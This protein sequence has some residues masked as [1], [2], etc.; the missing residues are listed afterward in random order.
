MDYNS[1]KVLWELSKSL[2]VIFF[3]ISFRQHTKTNEFEKHIQHEK[4][5][6]IW[7]NLLS[8]Y[9]YKSANQIFLNIDV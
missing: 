4:W 7:E 8:K 9:A 1:S 3:I 5:V 6:P 2:L